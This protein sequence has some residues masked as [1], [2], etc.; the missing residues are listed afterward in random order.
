VGFSY[1]YQLAL[2]AV[3]EAEDLLRIS[4]WPKVE[5]VLQAIDAIE[6]LGVDRTTHLDPEN[7]ASQRSS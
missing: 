1:A 6:Q 5:R 2:E 4:R 3:A 7:V